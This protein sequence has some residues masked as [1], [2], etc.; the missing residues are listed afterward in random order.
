MLV[1]CLSEETKNSILTALQQIVLTTIIL[2]YFMLQQEKMTNFHI[3]ICT[4]FISAVTVNGQS[5]GT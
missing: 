4:L 1:I 3:L 5:S 2:L